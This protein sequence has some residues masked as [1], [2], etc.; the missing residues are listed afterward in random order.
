MRNKKAKALR[1]QA[2][3]IAEKL[4]RVTTQCFCSVETVKEEVDGKLKVKYKP[5]FYGVD[6]NHPR[7]IRRAYTR[8]GME[9]VYAYL[10]SIHK[11]QLENNAQ[12]AEENVQSI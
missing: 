12:L 8:H 7:R 10:D 9:G 3:A 1:K 5:N 4:P 11:L 2:L 6:S